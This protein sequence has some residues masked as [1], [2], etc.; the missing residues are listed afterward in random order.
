ME[1]V[2]WPL[3]MPKV[4]STQIFNKSHALIEFEATTR[5]TCELCQVVL[6]VVELYDM[7]EY[8]GEYYEN[9]NQEW[10]LSVPG[11]RTEMVA[12]VNKFNEYMTDYV[13]YFDWLYSKAMSGEE[14]KESDD[15]VDAMYNLTEV[16]FK[17]RA[18]IHGIWRTI[19][20]EKRVA[21]D[22]VDNV[23]RICDIMEV[24]YDI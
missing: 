4:P 21:Q 24:Y 1:F 14:D 20:Y 9:E 11:D 8:A 18:I 6:H 13:K 23:Q 12:M 16:L 7:P 15:I 2:D 10:P 3:T 5:A 17:A 19:H 22:V